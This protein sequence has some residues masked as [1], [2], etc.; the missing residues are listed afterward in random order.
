MRKIAAMIKG[1]FSK[2]DLVEVYSDPD[3]EAL[4][5]SVTKWYMEVEYKG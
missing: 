1:L 2:E 4:R 5:I 3:I